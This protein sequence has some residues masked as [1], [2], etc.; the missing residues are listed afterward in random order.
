MGADIAVVLSLAGVAVTLVD[1]GEDQLDLARARMQASVATLSDNDLVTQEQA[2]EAFQIVSGTT[3]RADGVENA[4]FVV[5]S[6]PEDLVLKRDI[7][8]ALD[9]EAPPEAILT[10]NTSSLSIT[11]SLLASYR[12]PRGPRS[13]SIT[14]MVTVMVA[15]ASGGLAAVTSTVY[16]FSPDS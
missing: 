9:S 1:I 15:P 7:F 3:D 16:V 11:R 2:T 10:S 5:E 6:V 12:L 13:T 8:A 14:L 4:D